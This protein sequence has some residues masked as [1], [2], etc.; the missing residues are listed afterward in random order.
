MRLTLPNQFEFVNT[1]SL[2][3][4]RQVMAGGLMLL[5]LVAFEVFNFDTTQYALAN[6]LGNV[7]FAGLSWAT[8]L[9]IAFCA[10]DFAGLS[11]IFTPETG[12]KEPRAIWYLT[13]AWILGATMNA[14]MTWWAINL[15]LL[16][17]DFGNEVL[18]RAQ[19]LQGVPIFVAVLVWLTRILFIGSLALAGDQMWRGEQPATGAG[20]AATAPLQPVRLTPKRDTVSR[21]QPVQPPTRVTDELT[22]IHRPAPPAE[23]SPVSPPIPTSQTRRQPAMMEPPRH[24]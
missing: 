16:N 24:P 22:R 4:S 12:W 5:A 8:I 7:S 20:Q 21:E 10:I 15:T 19:L 17:H 6:L 1:P 2:K 23:R 18:S 9:A 13:G 11:R 3:A 14:I